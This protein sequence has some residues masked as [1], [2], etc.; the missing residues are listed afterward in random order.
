V[1]RSISLHVGDPRVLLNALERGVGHDP[2]VT[3][4][5]VGV[6]ES[7]L[8]AE[9]SGVLPGDLG[10]IGHGVLEHDDVAVDRTMLLAGT[11]RSRK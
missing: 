9:P 3:S 2:R 4:Q 1:H 10:G 7:G 11:G 8:D 5:R 6:Y